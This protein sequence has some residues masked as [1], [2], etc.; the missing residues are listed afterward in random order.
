[1]IREHLF[2]LEG[3]TISYY[4]PINPLI[5]DLSTPKTDSRIVQ[6]PPML[7]ATSE[8]SNE[9]NKIKEND[10]ISNN[11]ENVDTKTCS[12]EPILERVSDLD[13]TNIFPTLNFN[14]RFLTL[15]NFLQLTC[16]MID[17]NLTTSKSSLEINFYIVYCDMIFI[18]RQR[19]YLEGNFGVTKCKKDISI[20]E[21][22][23][24]KFL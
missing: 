10:P 8:K 6:Q 12:V 16:Q 7:H 19:G 22:C 3:W 23:G 17:L 15:N 13:T 4:L 9:S 24:I 1:M 14:V 18:Y 5:I 11:N 21:K 2:S 20:E